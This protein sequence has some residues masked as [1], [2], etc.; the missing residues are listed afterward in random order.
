M[1]FYVDTHEMCREPKEGEQWT[2]WFIGSSQNNRKGR[3][4]TDIIQG[5]EVSLRAMTE[6]A[7]VSFLKNAYSRAPWLRAYR[8]TE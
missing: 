4:F 2:A 3:E 8:V 7:L 1:Y 5:E 6:E